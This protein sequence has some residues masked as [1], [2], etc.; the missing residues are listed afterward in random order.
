MDGMGFGRLV[1]CVLYMY[2][3]YAYCIDDSYIHVLL[4]TYSSA[5]TDCSRDFVV[6]LAVRSLA[7]HVPLSSRFLVPFVVFYSFSSSHV[8]TPQ[9]YLGLFYT[10]PAFI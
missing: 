7:R 5:L 10:I 9:L 6:Y 2:Q 1:A 4:G 3:S 8:R